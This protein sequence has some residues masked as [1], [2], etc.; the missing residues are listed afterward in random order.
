M[1]KDLKSD[2]NTTNDTD[3]Q[4]T[5]M[6]V[7]VINLNSP[8]QSNPT[9]R[10][11]QTAQPNIVMIEYSSQQADSAFTLAYTAFLATVLFFSM[12]LF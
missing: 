6:Y 7:T 10:V 9:A 11:L 12:H 3:C 8:S 1:D 4:S 5:Q 2:L